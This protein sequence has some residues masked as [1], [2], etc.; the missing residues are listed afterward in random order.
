[1]RRFIVWCFPAFVVLIA[2]PAVGGVHSHATEA[3]PGVEFYLLEDE[4]MDFETARTKPLAD[5]VLQNLPWIAAEN[6]Q[7]YDWSSHYVYLKKPVAVPLPAGRKYVLLRGTPFV[8]VAGGQR[9]YLGALWTPLSSFAPRGSVAMITTMGRQLERFEFSLHTFLRAEEQPTDP[10]AD[11]RVKKALQQHGRFHAGLECS[12]DDVRVERKN[13]SCSVV[14]TFTV[15]NNDE[16]DLYV[17]D[18]KRIDPT[19]FHDFQNG[20][21]GR[22]AATDTSF[23]WPNPRNGD[24]Q[25]TPWGKLD[26]ER[27]SRLKKGEQMTRSVSMDGMPRIRPGKYECLFAFGSGGY[28]DAKK[29]QLQLP[30]GR[31]WLGRITAAST[32]EVPEK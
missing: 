28:S 26:A 21:S 18:P 10:R 2:A 25:P 29:E 24:P 6:I 4:Q 12:L 3:R 30:G 11:T 31:L 13:G 32:V 15:R 8:V 9:C 23:R 14:Y 27:F 19:F 20:V 16:D 22:N 17:L 1:M 7:R 5:L